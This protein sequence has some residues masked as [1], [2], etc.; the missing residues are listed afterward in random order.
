MKNQCIHAWDHGNDD[1]SKCQ[2]GWR[3]N[4][5]VWKKSLPLTSVLGNWKAESFLLN[6]VFYF[7]KNL[8]FIVTQYTFFF[9]KKRKKKA[10]SKELSEVI[11]PCLNESD[12]NLLIVLSIFQLHMKSHM[13][14]NKFNDEQKK[15]K[16]KFT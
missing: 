15:I 14:A 6:T 10:L 11:I 16:V 8:T 5:I 3:G 4:D 2:R 7:L 9:K 12:N 13:I 1:M